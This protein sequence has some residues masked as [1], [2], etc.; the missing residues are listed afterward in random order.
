MSTRLDAEYL[1]PT[2]LRVRIDTHR[3]YSENDHHP[4]EDVLDALALT[5]AEALADIGCGDARFLADLVAAGHRGPLVGVDTSPAMVAAAR[6]VPGVAGVLADAERMPFEDGTFDALT[7]RHMLY[8][9]PDPQAALGEFRRTTKPGG[10]VAIVVNHPHTCPRTAELVA[11]HASSY[12]VRPDHSFRAS[13]DS[14]TLPAL[15]AEVFDSVEVHRSDNALVFESAAPLI[16]FAESL[17]GFHGVPADHPDRAAV[18]ED[19]RTDVTEWFDAHPGAVWRD[20]KG[21]IV[22]V[23]RTDNV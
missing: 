7:A 13:V 8:H 15:M 5:G 18:L 14:D 1:D 12:G 11:A 3:R 4:T 9:V 16:R 21:Y 10:A 22:A 17:L 6:T 2:P 23:A 19:L 20:P